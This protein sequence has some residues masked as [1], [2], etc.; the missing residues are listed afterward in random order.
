M[1]VRRWAVVGAGGMLGREVVARLEAAGEPVTVLPRARL[2]VRDAAA[3]RRAL[4]DHDVVVNA[5]A[6][7]AVDAA[8]TAEADAF[9]VNATAVAHLAAAATATGARLVQ[10]ST[11]YV[12]GGAPGTRTPLDEGTPLSPLSAYGRT[13]AAGEWAAAAHAPD[14]LVVRTAW[15]YGDGPCFPRTMARLLRERD[16]LTVVDDQE[17]QPT[18]ARDVA[19]VLVELV[20]AEAAPGVHHATS[21]GSTTWLG[22]ARAVAEHL[23][24]DL[25]RVGPTT[26]AA[27]AL[28]AP[29]PAWSVLGHTALERAGVAPP[30]PWLERWREAAPEVLG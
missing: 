14:A 28:P 26:S 18:W 5:A 8:E 9:A 2:D 20:A 27:L 22:L 15:L 24:A 29:R 12:L 3:C 7:T 1:V 13:K 19:R 16:R 11:D 17:G 10:V 25:G 30:G 23:G 4:A 6:W 21:T